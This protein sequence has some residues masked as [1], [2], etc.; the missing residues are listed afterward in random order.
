MDI[1]L[2]LK[3]GSTHPWATWRSMDMAG[4]DVVNNALK[5]SS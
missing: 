4:V 5:P 1:D 2:G 3:L